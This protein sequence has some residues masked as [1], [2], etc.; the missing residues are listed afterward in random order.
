MA[1]KVFIKRK[2]KE[3]K[4][5]EVPNLLSK[6]RYGA[7]EQTGYISSETLSDYHDPNRVVVVSMWRDLQNWED[8]KNSDRRKSNETDF[9]PLLDGPT[10]YEICNMGITQ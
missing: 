7:M 10:D 8:W 3:G 6:A 2:I 9:E 4:L 5:P 1:I